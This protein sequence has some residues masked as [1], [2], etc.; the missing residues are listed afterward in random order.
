MQQDAN[1]QIHDIP[2]ATEYR[3]KHVYLKMFYH[4]FLE[5]SATELLAQAYAAENGVW[6]GDT[7]GLRRCQPLVDIIVADI[8]LFRSTVEQWSGSEESRTADESY[9]H[10]MFMQYLVEVALP[11]LAVLFEQTATQYGLSEIQIRVGQ[12]LSAELMDLHNKPLPL[13]CSYVVVDTQLIQ[14][15]EVVNR[16]LVEILTCLNQNEQVIASLPCLQNANLQSFL[17][18]VFLSSCN[19]SRMRVRQV[20]KKLSSRRIW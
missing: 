3:M 12:V 9:T 11:F 6:E 5:T 20:S 16:T 2:K 14:V 8:T 18:S 1:G 17:I 13:S 15:K 19:A 7:I 10:Q 4:V